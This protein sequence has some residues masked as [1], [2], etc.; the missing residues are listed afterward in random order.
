[1]DPPLPVQDSRTDGRGWKNMHAVRAQV[2]FGRA[3]GGATVVELCERESEKEMVRIQVHALPT[4]RAAAAAI[5]LES[6][7]L[8]L[9]P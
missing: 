7:S 5:R 1:M 6:G 4:R 8:S 2:A 3:V 9:S